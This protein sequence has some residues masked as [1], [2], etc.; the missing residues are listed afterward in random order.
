M[1]SVH[2]QNIAKRFGSTEVIRQLD[3]RIDSGEFVV[4]VGAS[5]SGKSTLLRM[6]AGLE[7]VS[8]GRVLI[9]DRDVTNR[10][11]SERGVSMVF[12]SYALYPHMNVRQNIAFGLELARSARDVIAARV[13]EVAAMLQIEDLLDRKPAQLSGGQ[14]QRVA[15]ARAIIRKPAVFLFDEPLSNLDAALRAHTRLEIARLHQSLGATMVYVTHDQTEAMS[16]ADRMVMLKDGRIEQ[17]GR[18]DELYHRP[19]TRYVASFLGTPAMNFLVPRCV[20]NQTAELESGE[21]LAL[22]ACDATRVRTIGVRPE[23]IGIGDS[24]IA[25]TVFHV[26]E[27]GETRI[28]HVRIG[29]QELAIRSRSIDARQVGSVVR[30]HL[31]VDRLHLFDEDDRRIAPSSDP[32]PAD[33]GTG[34]APSP[35]H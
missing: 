30:L 4:F 28:A 20:G 3:L 29:R 33:A 8:S 13:S 31:P 10:P 26:E 14:R 15:I 18:P 12:Q 21:T 19:A 1:A 34:S 16:L 17:V 9:G 25:A 23:D 24:G 22:P 5:G 35:A 32:Q 2:L 7:A 27:L 6:I 11:P